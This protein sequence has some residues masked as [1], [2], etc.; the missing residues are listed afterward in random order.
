MRE[1]DQLCRPTEFL[2]HN[3]GAVREFALV[4][5]PVGAD[6]QLSC[7]Q[8]QRPRVIVSCAKLRQALTL[9]RAP[10]FELAR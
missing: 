10:C 9:G 2:A 1:L 6:S 5:L 8:P 7:R 4:A 3:D